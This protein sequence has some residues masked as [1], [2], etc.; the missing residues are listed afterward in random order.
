MAEI[1][2]VAESTIKRME[3]VENTPPSSGQNLEKVQTALEGR[4][5]QFLDDGQVATGPGVALKPQE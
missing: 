1:S 3:L 4:G 5:I 2:G